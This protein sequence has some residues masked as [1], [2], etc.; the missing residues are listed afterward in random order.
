MFFFYRNPVVC[1]NSIHENRIFIFIYIFHGENITAMNCRSIQPIFSLIK[2]EY[3]T[4]INILYKHNVL[5][6][7]AI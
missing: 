7:I 3:N 4:Y 5:T 2:N 1:K 6:I